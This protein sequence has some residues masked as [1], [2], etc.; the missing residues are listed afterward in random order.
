MAKEEYIKIKVSDIR[1][2]IIKIDELLHSNT[3]LHDNYNSAWLNGE[4]H[5]LKDIL[6]KGVKIVKKL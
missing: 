4:L 6:S 2:R 3:Y 5:T 1:D